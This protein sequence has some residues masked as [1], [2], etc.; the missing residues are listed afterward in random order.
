M[1]GMRMRRGLLLMISFFTMVGL[2]AGGPVVPARILYVAP[3]GSDS[4]SGDLSEPNGAGTDGPKASLAGARDAIRAWRGD[5]PL[6]EPVTV[7][8][9]GG[10]YSLQEPF[11]LEPEDSGTADAPVT[12]AA[13][14]GEKPIFS[15][16]RKLSGFESR[17][18]GILSCP[19]PAVRNGEW[20]FR[21]LFVNGKRQTRARTPNE[22]YFYTAG[23]AVA[24]EDPET[25]EMIKRDNIAFRFK[26]GDIPEFHDT[27]NV[28][29]VVLHSWAESRHRIAEIDRENSEITFTGPARWNFQRW[30]ARQRYYLENY[31]GAL[32]EPGEWFLDRKNGVLTYL[33][34]PEEGI[35][36]VVAPVIKQFVL[37]QGD[38]DNGRYVEHVGLSGLSFQY[39]S[40]GLPLEGISDPQAAVSI[41]AAIHAQGARHCTIEDCEVAHIGVYGIWLERGCSYNRIARNHIH[42]LGAG[43]VRIG[44]TRTAKELGV[45]THHNTVDN[46]WIHDGGHVYLAAVGVWIG[47]SDGNTVSH[48]EISD[49]YYTGISVGWSWGYAPSSAKENLIEYNH[50]HHIGWSVLSDMGGIYTLGI[51]PGTQI[52]HNIFHHISSYYYGGWGIYPDEGSTYLVIE[53]NVVYE[54]KTGGFHQHY[55]RDNLVRNNIFAFSKEGQIQRTR[56]EEH[57]SFIFDRNIVYFDEGKLLSSNWASPD[58]YDMDYNVY[59]KVGEGT[60]EF[61]GMSFEEWRDQGEDKHSIIAD[62]MFRDPEIYDFRLKDGSPVSAVHFIPIA[63]G[64]VG[65]YGDPEWMAAPKGVARRPFPFLSPDSMTSIED[66]FEATPLRATASYAATLKEQNGASI[67]VT[68][69]T[70]AS[71]E[72]SLKFVDAAGLGGSWEPFL[73]YTVEMTEGVCTS[74]FDMRVKPGAEPSVEW[75]TIASAFGQGPYVR[76]DGEGNLFSAGNEPLLQVPHGTWF[77]IE[78]TCPLGE[79]ADGMYNLTVTIPGEDPHEFKGLRCTDKNFDRITWLGFIADATED[80]VFYVD[81]VV[82]KAT[83]GK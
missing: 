49:F 76:I 32:D 30:G 65:L 16:G 47:R 71:G 59:W 45:A 39:G 19:V 25:G 69:E 67:R 80:A 58:H 48:N 13:Y 42:D 61:A 14:P 79:R 50:V 81:N 18:S 64:E 5:G 26:P 75:R 40:W 60:P 72:R 74:S 29:V 11:V 1:E 52:R 20:Y 8:V 44:E 15:G 4:W 82:L 56:D 62:P 38:P 27:D 43:G 78:M 41:P 33:E 21:Q 7:W 77:S 3:D 12:Y 83:E 36:D 2:L 57:R 37:I 70:A 22:G 63:T 35:G 17:E 53:N 28:N 31:E 54:T 10:E 34:K 51:S 24:E 68:D 66:D 6:M 9:R 73:A 46:N 23:N 55:G